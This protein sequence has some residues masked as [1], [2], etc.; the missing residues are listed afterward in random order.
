MNRLVGNDLLKKI[1]WSFVRAF[2]GTFAVG[3]A[4][5]LAS[6]NFEAGKAALIALAVASV[7]AGI[8]AA[9]AILFAGSPH[10]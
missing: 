1:A 7:T 6:P 2:L 3:V 9:Q 10:A 4:G 8:R 5:V